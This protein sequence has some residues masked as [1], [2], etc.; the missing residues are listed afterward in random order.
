MKSPLIVRQIV[1]EFQEKLLKLMGDVE[2]SGLSPVGFEGLLSNLKQIVNEAG[3]K[4]FIAVLDGQDETDD[5]IEHEGQRYRFKIA[6][7]KKWLTPFG[8][9]KVWRRYYQPDEGGLGMMPLDVRCGMEGRYMTPDV[10]EITT[11]ASAMLVPQE[12]KALL[13]KMLPMGPSKTGIQRVIDS[14]G[15]WAESYSEDLAEAM[16][17]SRPLS[18]KG[19][20]LV[21]S[22][23]GVMVPLR[24]EAP[25]RGRPAERPGVR[26][27][28]VSPTAWK[29]AGVAAV[30]IY[31]EAEEADK[32]PERVD[33]RYMARMPESG[34]ERLL[35]QQAELVQQTL[36]SGHFRERV[37]ICDGKPAIWK[38]ADRMETYEGFTYILDFYHAAEALSHASEAI[39]GKKSAEGTRWFKKYRHIMRTQDGGAKKTLR[40]MRRYLREGGLRKGSERHKVLL[41]MIR[42]FAKNRSK[43][44]YADY[45]ARGL[46]IGSGPVEAACKTVVGARL[47]RSGMR[48]SRAGGQHVLNLRVHVL[49]KRWEVFWQ[50][51]SRKRRA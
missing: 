13:D 17:S 20:I 19:D 43:M 49:S 37:L 23:D 46:P 25:H 27:D 51:Y 35:A 26:A 29:E 38:A 16:D 18:T 39:F 41:K 10:E 47:K 36:M 2:K 45:R 6:S 50:E 31:R 14:V 44:D 5:I 15:D 42:Y 24:E 40:S 4:A 48:W 7:E 12:V 22:W 34:M 33:T 8:Q 9:A 21:S 1:D 28:E 30:S 32:P 3:L 11:F